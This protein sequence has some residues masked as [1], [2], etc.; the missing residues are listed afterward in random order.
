MKITCVISQ[1]VPYTDVYG[2]MKQCTIRPGKHNYPML[3]PKNDLLLAE[4]LRVLRKHH[5]VAFDDLLPSDQEILKSCP[6]GVDRTE[7]LAEKVLLKPSPKGRH[8]V[9]KAVKKNVAARSRPKD[10]SVTPVEK[11]SGDGSKSRKVSDKSKN[12]SR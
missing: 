8:V 10:T 5:K 2:E 7:Y 9:K 6:Q 3:R 11:P 1:N 12:S 4:A